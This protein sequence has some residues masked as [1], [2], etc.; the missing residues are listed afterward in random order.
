MTCPY[1]HGRRVPCEHC[2]G[3]RIITGP[4]ASPDEQARQEIALEIVRPGGLKAF[5]DR[6]P[7]RENGER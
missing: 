5:M 2:H 4:A 6:H 3:T 7:L 1:C